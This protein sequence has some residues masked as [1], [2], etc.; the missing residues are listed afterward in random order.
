MG[1]GRYP[2]SS[3]DVLGDL[4]MTT[5]VSLNF[6]QEAYAAETG[7]VL[8]ALIT[9]DHADLTTP[10]RISTDPTQRLTEYTT[11]ADIVYGTVSRGNTFIFL[12]VRLKLPDDT[13]AGPGE[14][15]IEID[16]V[17]RDYTATIRSI[18]SP[19]TVTVELV[20]DN[21]LDTVE[22]Q[23]PEFLL[24]D[25]E[26]DASVITGTMKMETL[27]REPFPAGTFA[28]SYFPGLF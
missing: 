5:S 3:F 23:W 21:T 11:D 18:Y 25:I 26:Y 19:V 22:A 17:H 28:P 27:E 10:I 9:L 1:G 12:P 2:F 16:N 13:D 14:M 20:M 7:R 15:T 4:A 8:I 24:T 6:R